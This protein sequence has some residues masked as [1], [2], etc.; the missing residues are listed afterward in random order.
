[1]KE[2]NVANASM[3]QRRLQGWSM[4]LVSFSVLT[5]AFSFGLFSLP[6]FYPILTK[7]FGWTH[8]EAAA[9]GSIVLLLIGI[10]GPLIGRLTDRYKPKAV[11]LAGM[12]V[13]ALSLALLST[14]GSL[15]SF[16]AFCI[17][18]G[19]G[20]AAVSLVPTSILIA[21][22]FSRKRGTAVGVINA[23]VGVGG[24]V[25]PMLAG[26]L[27]DR[28]GASEAFFSLALFIAIPF[29]LTVALVRRQASPAAAHART[30]SAEASVPRTGQLVKTSLFWLLAL[31]LF[32]AAH[33]LTG[34]QQHLVLYLTGAG[35][36]PGNARF[37]L[38][39]LLGASAFGKLLGGAAAD[40]YSTRVSLLLSILCL[41]IGIGGLL[42]AEPG[43]AVIYWIAAAFGLGYGGVFNAPSIIAFE[44][45]GTEGVGTIL[46]LFMMFFGLG[47]SSGGL[48][49]GMIYD[50]T[51]RYAS[52][53]A[54]DLASCTLAAVLLL[55]LR[56]NA[57]PR[58][59]AVAAAARKA[60]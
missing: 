56:S 25:A 48:V 16:Y 11:L 38:S 22:W 45:F 5:V 7:K 47:T 60:V 3:P 58:P 24:F 13:G 50:Q 49:A 8:A 39:V 53:F 26:S 57:R 36:N 35:V 44:Y 46:G 54:V 52:S 51:H 33:T 34:I 14:A 18:L 1:M 15:G 2:G 59:D 19:I 43:A 42:T 20:S 9:G 41:V 12:C 27:I 32:F 29:V 28:Q 30:G 10:L 6:V 31:S 37:A 40:R 4:L 23:G 55:M 21:P 17:L